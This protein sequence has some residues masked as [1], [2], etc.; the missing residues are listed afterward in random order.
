MT[1]WLDM[2]NGERVWDDFSSI[3][4]EMLIKHYAPQIRY[5]AYR[6]KVKLP[7]H[8]DISEL[9]SAGTLGLMESLKN[10]RQ[11]WVFALKRMPKAESEGRCLMNSDVWIGF[12]AGSDKGSGK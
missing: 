7:K 9:I 3:E 6:M 10:I 5:L 2:E 12:R 1:P 4:K 8:I 11:I